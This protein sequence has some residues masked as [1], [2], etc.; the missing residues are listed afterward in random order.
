ME[1]NSD[2]QRKNEKE[3]LRLPSI[4][5][6][7]SFITEPRPA[8]EGS[9][10]ERI[11]DYNNSIRNHI[12]NLNSDIDSVLQ[13]HEQDFLNAFKCQMYNLYTQ[14]KELKKAAS[15]TGVNVKHNEELHKLQKSLEWYQ[16]EAAK[17]G[18]TVEEY[19]QEIEIWKEK[20]N[21]LETD[22]KFYKSRLKN[23]KRKLKML[24]SQEQS[25]DDVQQTLI[26]VVETHSPS[27][28]TKFVPESKSGE[29]ISELLKKYN[30][31]ET[32]LFKDIEILMEKQAKSFAESAKH[33]QSII[34]NE[35]KKMQNLS[36]MQ[37]SVF[38]EKSDL[39]NLFLDCVEE[40]KKEIGHRR[41]KSLRLQKF[42]LKNKNIPKEKGELFSPGD[43]RK[44]MEL[45]ISNE[46]VLIMLY[47][48]LF[49]F[50]ASQFGNQSKLE[51]LSS[52]DQ[53]TPNLDEMMKSI[54]NHI[55][56]EPSNIFQS[57]QN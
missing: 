34:L 13:R 51:N 10:I 6:D 23:A 29:I 44:I 54:S 47:E 50:R 27:P 18:K 43:K 9:T 26:T 49:P 53:S 46:Q 32:Q 21:E 24:K 28:L 2:K 35:R 15:N 20:S 45:L 22:C 14:I 30:R 57:L 38:L 7:R 52:F 25:K 40:V 12:L 11:N 16:Q 41:A 33:Y 31:K 48:K 19:K 17:L 39:E 8:K 36:L 55:P 42:P 4:V 1:N 37:S 56:T 5:T 3:L